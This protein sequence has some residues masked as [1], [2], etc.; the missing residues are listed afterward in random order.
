MIEPKGPSRPTH[1][2]SKRV[3]WKAVN[4][5]CVFYHVATDFLQ[6]THQ[7]PRTPVRSQIHP[8]SQTTRLFVSLVDLEGY[9]CDPNHPGHRICD[10]LEKTRKNP[11]V[12]KEPFRIGQ[13]RRTS[14][15]GQRPSVLPLLKELRV[16]PSSRTGHVKCNAR[17]AGQVPLELVRSELVG[18]RPK[19]PGDSPSIQ[20]ATSL[21]VEFRTS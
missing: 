21:S 20:Q 19:D 17:R 2:C 12:E 3:H 5:S 7:E 15:T 1:V 11:P 13:A 16:I 18:L 9:P 8:A 4:S 6:L 10:A 14:L